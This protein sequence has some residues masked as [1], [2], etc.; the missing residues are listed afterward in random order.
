MVG[1]SWNFGSEL[2]G[3]VHAARSGVAPAVRGGSDAPSRLN[4]VL[5]DTLVDTGHE[6]VRRLAGVLLGTLIDERYLVR[7]R[8]GR[9]G[10]AEVYGV[11]DQDLGLERALKLLTPRVGR[12]TAE[13]RFHQE[14][15]LC[16]ALRH[17][18]LVRVFDAGVWEG[19][20]YYTMELLAGIDLREYLQ[21][22]PGRGIAL[23]PAL[24]IAMGIADGLVA[25]HAE[26]IVHRDVKPANVQLVP[27][28]ER[29]KLVDFGIAF[30][31]HLALDLTEPDVVVGTPAYVSPERITSSRP[32]TPQADLYS[33][34]VILY[35]MLA[36]HRPFEG[37]SVAGLFDRIVKEP[38]PPL[39]Q[40]VPDLP[41]ELEGLIEG[42]MA[43]RPCDRPTNAA[44]TLRRLQALVDEL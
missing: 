23:R 5:D 26:G 21:L 35:E 9:G 43:K 30:A 38:A 33:L 24:E 1:S 17:R 22:A 31:G 42:L 32:P 19:R 11:L 18:N 16:Q 4:S 12:D 2:A 39:R 44:Y 13:A 14:I 37:P 27:G 36:G 7:R 40:W 3:G 28:P 25:V 20:L 29:V 8:I 15:R 34:G 6:P 10:S 41:W